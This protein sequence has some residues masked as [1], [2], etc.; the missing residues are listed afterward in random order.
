MQFGG[1]RPAPTPKRQD[2]TPCHLRVTL[3]HR[4]RSYRPEVLSK[5]RE[6]SMK[7]D[8]TDQMAREHADRLMASAPAAHLAKRAGKSRRAAAG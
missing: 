4:I 7:P 2:S 6:D 1:N 8:I 5:T 3:T